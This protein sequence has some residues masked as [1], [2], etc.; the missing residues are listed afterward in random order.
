MAPLAWGG[1]RLMARGFPA[2]V[3]EVVAGPWPLDHF[4]SVF[5]RSDF[6]RRFTQFAVADLQFLF[7]KIF[8]AQ[9]R[10]G[11]G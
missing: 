3:D 8:L 7:L 11:D 2:S 6:L 1:K 9:G 4:A 5:V 10:G